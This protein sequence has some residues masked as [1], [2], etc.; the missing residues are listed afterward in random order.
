MRHRVPDRLE[1]GSQGR[2]AT[3][4]AGASGLLPHTDGTFAHSIGLFSDLVRE[5]PM[6]SAI[7]ALRSQ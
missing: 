3:I 6:F 7:S 1:G 5:W 4:K 2:Y